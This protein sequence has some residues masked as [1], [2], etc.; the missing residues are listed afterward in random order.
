MDKNRKSHQPAMTIEEQIANLRTK[1]L[2]VSDEDFARATLADIS[3]FRL[4]KAYSL[5]LKAKNGDYHKGVRFEDIVQ[6]YLFDANLRQVIFPL[7]ERIEINLRCRLANHFSLTYGVFGYED[8]T[9]FN[10]SDENFQMFYAEILRELNRKRRTPFIINFKDSYKGGKIPMYALMEILSFGTLSKLYKNMH[11][12]DKK[13]VAAQF[14]VSYTYL[15]SW[16]EHLSYV[17][18]ICAHYGRLYNAKLAKM[19]R[20]Y[21]QYTARGISNTRTFVT[22]LTLKHLLPNGRHWHDFVQT[23]ELL[24]EKYQSVKL[25]KLGFPHDWRDM[26]LQ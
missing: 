16:L 3:Y 25:H 17:R 26:L 12:K 8:A 13:V 24:I 15:E 5:G 1:G 2:L 10:V 19:P 7:I 14:G 21:K 11:N 20:L 22:L 18:N 4:I 6:L 9:N 23:I